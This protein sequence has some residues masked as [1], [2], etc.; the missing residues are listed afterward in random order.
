MIVG[1]YAWL[2]GEMRRSVID[3]GKKEVVGVDSGR[4]PKNI[5]TQTVGN[6]SLSLQEDEVQLTEE[7]VQHHSNAGEHYCQQ[8]RT[9]SQPS[10]LLTIGLYWPTMHVDD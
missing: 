4:S 8:D 6:G 10:R 7:G 1:L 9:L 5:R 3:G 2:E